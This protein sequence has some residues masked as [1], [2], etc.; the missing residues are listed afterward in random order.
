MLATQ[1]TRTAKTDEFYAITCAGLQKQAQ[2]AY[3]AQTPESVA[4]IQLVEHLIGRKRQLAKRTWQTYKAAVCAQLEDAIEGGQIGEA[5]S[6]QEVQELQYA[7][8]ML[9]AQSQTEALRH[10]NRT[11]ALKAKALAGDDMQAICD[12][13]RSMSEG[14]V[15][16]P[17]R[18][19]QSARA[20]MTWCQASDLVG[21]RPSEWAHA[22]RLDLADGTPMLKV[23]NAKHTHDRGNGEY[24][25]LDLS[26]L[27]PEQLE[28]IDQQLELIDGYREPEAFQTLV[29]TLRKTLSR[30]A[31]RVLSKRKKYPSLYTFRHQFAAD[32]KS[33][34]NG[35]STVAALMGHASDATAGR[36]Y[37]KAKVGRGGVNVAPVPSEVATVRQKARAQPAKPSI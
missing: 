4:P 13:L 2:R 28:M 18:R 23:R 19:S 30:V 14:S 3:G 16:A 12:C 24:R 15:V 9:R 11:S 7:L 33:A 5:S 26:R 6:L 21:L 20:L 8:D 10:T 17:G 27:T 37:A 29:G 34:M 31:R 22:D 32:A 1:R 36:N 25:H 35:R